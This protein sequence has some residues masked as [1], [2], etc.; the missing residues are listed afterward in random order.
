LN[1]E[2]TELESSHLLHPG[3]IDEAIRQRDFYFKLYLK[4]LEDYRKLEEDFA[5]LKKQKESL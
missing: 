3:N 2:L 1:H 4:Q 5:K